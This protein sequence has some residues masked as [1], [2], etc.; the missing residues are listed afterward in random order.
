MKLRKTGQPTNWLQFAN[1]ALSANMFIEPLKAGEHPLCTGPLRLL[2]CHQLEVH[3]SPIPLS[4]MAHDNLLQVTQRN[5]FQ[6]KGI[7][8]SKTINIY[9]PLI[10]SRVRYRMWHEF[11]ETCS[12]NESI[13]ML[14]FSSWQSIWILYLFFTQYQLFLP[15]KM[16]L[17]WGFLAAWNKL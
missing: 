10:Y 13:G 5:C 7:N 8:L 2:H 6:Q 15:C 1:R 3:S 4:I 16:R 17:D 9:N 14:F 12:L 11:T